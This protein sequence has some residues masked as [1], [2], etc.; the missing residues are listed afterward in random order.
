MSADKEKVILNEKSAGITEL[1]PDPK[2]QP[3]KAAEESS[4]GDSMTALTRKDSDTIDDKTYTYGLKPV[5]AT[6]TYA[7][8]LNTKTGEIEKLRDHA[9]ATET[10]T[11][12]GDSKYK[13]GNY[14]AKPA[15]EKS[16]GST[17]AFEEIV[18]TQAD[19]AVVKRMQGTLEDPNVTQSILPE[20]IFIDG[21]VSEEDVR[22]GGIGDCYFLASLLQVI[23]HDPSKILNM[24]SVSGS[25]VTTTFYHKEKTS[26][27][28]WYGGT[29]E[30]EHW[31][32]Q[33][34]S[35]QMGIFTQNNK[36]KTSHYRIAYD[37]KKATW[38]SSLSKLGAMNTLKINRD[39][40]YEAATWLLCIEQ[41]YMIFAQNYGRYG[42]G[43][44]EGLNLV[45]SI[46]GGQAQQCMYMFFGDKVVDNSVDITDV[47]NAD[48]DVDIIKDNQAIIKQMLE[49][50]KHQDG[51]GKSDV[52]MMA[53]ISTKTA[54]NHLKSYADMAAKEL[55]PKVKDNEDL[56][57]ALADI[58]AIGDK[59]SHYYDEKDVPG[60]EGE[61][62]AW[63]EQI[64]KDIDALSLSLKANTAFTSLNLKSYQTLQESVGIVVAKV[65][66][67]KDDYNNIFI[68]SAHAYSVDSLHLVDKKGKDLTQG[69]HLFASKNVD[70]DK[71]TVTLI[72]PH[73]KTKASFNEKEDRYNDGKFTVSLRSFLNN[74]GYVRSAEVKK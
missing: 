68:Y 14:V 54:V 51:K 58:Q 31:V 63:Q 48:E 33:D 59:A 41:A 16:V 36:Y 2:A 34:I 71:S 19:A 46:S 44:P 62:G 67:K 50:A 55:E 39:D 18:G 43:D 26:E 38:S 22:Q 65:T 70:A 64:R 25:T 53:G 42:K 3:S 23:R 12:D 8:H 21:T 4:S 47:N 29:K 11:E 45:D 60:R 52:Y 13:Q 27:K 5:T 17:P 40:V 73:G 49:Y 1:A 57:K 28:T 30:K 20:N 15:V 37:P 9:G 10:L 72:N 61:S 6:D 74:V 7:D 66:G 24:M 56:Q 35:V 32:S 69:F